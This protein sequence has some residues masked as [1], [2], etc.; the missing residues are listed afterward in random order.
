MDRGLPFGFFGEDPEDDP[1]YEG[2]EVDEHGSSDEELPE[3]YNED[4][5]DEE[6]DVEGGDDFMGGGPQLMLDRVS[7]HVP[8]VPPGA[9]QHI[10]RFLTDLCAF[11]PLSARP[12]LTFSS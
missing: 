2:E 1:D 8:A 11:S 4:S 3:G 10:F 7:F 12:P 6:V 9:G 5:E